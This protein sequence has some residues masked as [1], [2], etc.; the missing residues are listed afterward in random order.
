MRGNITTNEGALGLGDGDHSGRA[1][2]MTSAVT[3][4]SAN[5]WT[6]LAMLGVA[7]ATGGC[8]GR[9]GVGESA[10]KDSVKSDSGAAT[11]KELQLQCEK[12]SEGL[13]PGPAPLRRLTRAEYDRTVE[14]LLDDN[15]AP[16]SAFP[17]E[18]RALGFNGVAEAQTVTSLLV[19]AY[20]SAA[21]TL[22]DRA[23]A[24]LEGLLGC[25]AMEADCVEDFVARFGGLAYRRPVTEGEAARLVKV[26]EWGR[27][28]LN[29]SEG[30]QMVLEV[31]L[32]SPDFL[33]RPEFGDEIVEDGIVRLSSYEMATRLSYLFLGSS[34]DEELRLAAENNELVSPKQVA[35]QADRLLKD[36]R[37]RETFRS[38][39]SQWLNLEAVEHIERDADVYEGY[40]S[41]IPKLFRKETE[42]FIEHVIFENDGSLL[43]ML[44]APYTMANQQL[45]EFYGLPAL[46]G[47]EFQRVTTD[48]ERAGLLTQG[49]LL[50][51]HAQPLSTSPVHRGK[52]IRE[53]FFCQFPPAPP[54]DL[55]IVPP[56][57][58]ADL[59]TRERYAAHAADVS[60]ANCHKLMDPL[61]LGLEHFDP[62]GR[63][64]SKENGH[65]VDASGE[66][67]A[68]DIDGKFYGAVELGEGLAGSAQVATCLTKQW[69]RFAH[70]R[71][72]TPEDACT[73][74]EVGEKFE[75]TSYNI[76]ALVRE[77]TQTDAFLYREEVKP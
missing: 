20:L 22:A 77:L 54:A 62:V 56:E 19:E 4:R 23:S 66:F 26:F 27:D 30:I 42:G 55:I 75:S 50:A 14:D 40:E 33:Y 45:A 35:F 37:A 53:A 67:F 59:T 34:P 69:L 52:F 13:H 47:E 11:T 32:Q 21:E 51:H 16:G 61:G 44:T 76:P 46:E 38:F 49:S 72:E 64:R 68:T 63:Y 25:D 8:E 3:Y 15:S 31:L 12:L 7:T 71:S 48:A 43:T 57:L 5:I 24:D 6:L 36:D 74:S 17:P 73:L 10:A 65:D 70:G 58:D 60:C 28:N 2:A 1:R 41:N 39:H 9:L 29:L 18:A